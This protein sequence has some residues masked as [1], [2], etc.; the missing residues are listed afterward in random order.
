MTAADGGPPKRVDSLAA[1]LRGDG[2]VLARGRFRVDPAAALKLRASQLVDP[3]EYIS[4]L[5]SSA[6]LREATFVAVSVGVSRVEVLDDGVPYRHAELAD[7]MGALVDAAPRPTHARLLATGLNGAWDLD[8]ALIEIESWGGDRSARIGLERGG[9][10]SKELPL[11]PWHDSSAHVRVTI[12]KQPSLRRALSSLVAPPREAQIVAASFLLAPPSVSIT[13]NGLRVN[14]P[15]DFGRCM[16]ISRVDGPGRVELP[17]LAPARAAIRS[18]RRLPGGPAMV[19]AIGGPW[20]ARRWLGDSGAAIAFV[21]DGQ[22]V[23]EECGGSDRPDLGCSAMRAV[24]VDP[25]LRLDLARRRVVH[26]DAHGEV[27]A[28]VRDEVVALLDA[29]DR[30]WAPR[31]AHG[32]EGLAPLMLE[33]RIRSRRLRGDAAATISSL[34]KLHKLSERLPQAVLHAGGGEMRRLASALLKVG[35]GDEAVD[36]LEHLLELR[37]GRW[38]PISEEQ[39]LADLAACHLAGGRPDLSREESRSAFRLARE[40]YAHESSPL[41][42]LLVPATLLVEACRELD[43]GTTAESV[44]RAVNQELRRSRK[45]DGDALRAAVRWH[46]RAAEATEAERLVGKWLEQCQRALGFH[47]EDCHWRCLD[48]EAH[49]HAALLQLESGALDE[50]RA[51]VR[52]A[53]P[54]LTRAWGRLI[55]PWGTRWRCSPSSSAS[56]ARPMRRAMPP[57][58]RSRS[59]ARPS[60]PPIPRARAASG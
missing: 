54:A 7:V 31:S 27:L 11:R 48:A 15:A 42:D 4:S 57:D 23:V 29:V 56:G 53:L 17:A 52:A 41:A 24:V 6:L 36:L 30:E 49:L 32:S 39:A 8:L 46:R 45:W 58:A 22:A 43:D 13:V 12:V 59:A 18:E 19:V 35:R 9:G 14:R 33:D 50:A 55:P 25:R 38:R 1:H 21:V 28:T 16:A 51:S 5:V 44:A 60:A 47:P 2:A 34:A 3:Y 40:R 26:D 10:Q 37:R 20:Q